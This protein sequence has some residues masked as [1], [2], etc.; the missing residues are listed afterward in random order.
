MFARIVNQFPGY[1]SAIVLPS[2][3]RVLDKFLVY[4][5]LGINHS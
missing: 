1:G 5:L 4:F 3:P 2:L